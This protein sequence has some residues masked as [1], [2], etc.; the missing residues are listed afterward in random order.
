[1][2]QRPATITVAEG[3]LATPRPVDVASFELADFPRLVR[4]R[5]SLL[6]ARPAICVER[7]RL[8]TEFFEREGFGDS[9]ALILRARALEHILDNLPTPIFEDELIVGSTTRHRLG[10]LLYP[11]FLAQAIWPELPTIARREHD[12]VDIA[13]EEADVLADR[14]FPFW[15]DRTVSEH[16]RRTGDNPESLR[17]AEHLVF[18]MLPKA[19]GVT[20]IIP[21]YSAVVE[22][23]L[24][25]L[26]VDAAK[27]EGVAE[28]QEV[29]DFHRAV[30]ITLRSAIRF[31]ERYARACDAEAGRDGPERAEE[32]GEIASILRRVPARPAASLHEALQ[33]IWI[34]H[35]ALHQESNDVALSFGRLDQ[36]LRFRYERDVDAGR[37][38]RRRACELLG[39][40]FVKMG[41]HTPLIPRAAH[42][43]LGGVSTNQAVTIGGLT[44]DGRD[45]V[46]EL[47]FLMLKAAELLAL[48]EPNLCARVHRNSSAKYR[49]AVVE[50]ICKTGAAPAIYG[51]EAVIEALTHAG[52]ALADARDYGVIGCVET[53][54]AGRTMGM[55]GAIL[56]NVAAVLELALFDGIHPLTGLRVGPATG[57]LAGMGNFEEFFA[58][59]RRQLAAMVLLAVDGNA[60]FAR[61]HAELH[62]TPLLSALIEG[63]AESGHDVT[64]GG[65]K[66]NSSGVAV[67]GLADVADSLTAIRDVVFDRALVSPGDL[68]AALAAHFDGHEKTRALLLNKAPK[69]GTDEAAADSMA[70]AVVELMDSV[71]AAHRGP[72]GGRYNVGY[73]S[74]TMH[75]GFGALTGCLPNGRRKGEPLASGAT[76]VNG[77]AR[78]G[79]TAALA[80]TATLPARH[81]ANCIAV[82]HKLPRS[83]FRNGSGAVGSLGGLV[84]GYLRRGGMQVQF[85]VQDRETLLDAQANPDRHRDLLVRVSGYT[86]YF[87]DLN[88]RMQDEI[89]A[90][91]EDRV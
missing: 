52:V 74:I 17:I 57:E 45:G 8:V 84:D 80:S 23:G 26:I 54:S 87:C 33:A 86:A 41:D 46:N 76:P 58:A 43:L 36:V 35:V 39:S 51:D 91:T 22:R 82:N 27:R 50:S 53:T 34:T 6:G 85:T 3:P 44:P 1:M 15:R 25:W 37:I 66:Y 78:K 29:A 88:R 21:N 68:A 65:A 71:F 70:A 13:P 59:F 24:E 63:T 77:V 55:T 62:P 11:E 18:Y 67:I 89:I 40:F 14:V 12:P 32:L 30:Q 73:W 64:R 75:A 5:S 10:C 19:N 49:R 4:L 38:D 28:E 61:A 90:R 56:L 9:A 7:A 81:M 42:E 83:L 48:R 31:A 16:V 72:R 20:H 69:Y 79:P 2:V 47:T 60:R